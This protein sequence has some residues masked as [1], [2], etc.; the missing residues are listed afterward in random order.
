MKIV[1]AALWL[2]LLHGHTVSGQHDEEHANFSPLLCNGNFSMNCVPLN[3][4]DVKSSVYVVPC[5]ACQVLTESVNFVGGLNVEGHLQI[6]PPVNVTSVL[7]IE[8]PFIIV[9]GKL[10]VDMES[11]SFAERRGGIHIELVEGDGTDIQMVPHAENSMACGDPTKCNVGKR[12]FVVAGG[13]IDIRGYDESCPSWTNLVDVVE[14]GTTMTQL[15]A[16]EYE[17][18]PQPPSEVCSAIAVWQDFEDQSPPPNEWDGGGALEYGVKSTPTGHYFEATGNGPRVF[19]A[20]PECLTP[21]AQYLFSVTI[22][23]STL[24]GTASACS[25]YGGWN[26]PQLILKTSSGSRWGRR[27]GIFSGKDIDDGAW[28]TFQAAV[29]FTEAEVGPSSNN[30]WTSLS[31]SGLGADVKLSID[32]FLLELAPPATYHDPNQVC[33]QLLPNGDAESSSGGN[34]FPFTLSGGRAAVVEESGNKFFRQSGRYAYYNRLEAKVNTGCIVQDAVYKVSAKVQVHW[35]D[36]TPAEIVVASVQPNGSTHWSTLLL[37]PDSNE[38]SG[39]VSCEQQL[40]F[41]PQLIAATSIT[42]FIRPRG[43]G[44]YASTVDWDDLSIEYVSVDGPV[45]E[46]L[47]DPTIVHDCWAGPIS[48]GAEVLLTSHTLDYTDHQVVSTSGMTMDGKISL[49][50]PIVNPMSGAGD[51]SVEV[52]LLSRRITLEASSVSGSSI[53]GHFIVLHTPGVNQII[54]GME[55]KGFGQQGNLGRYV[56][57][58]ILFCLPICFSIIDMISL[59][60]LILLCFATLMCYIYSRS[61]S[62]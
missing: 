17:H 4:A 14:E 24:G 57:N 2:L 31:I 48:E 16:S 46:V 7:S 56:S 59:T 28:A 40:S 50:S 58:I 10:T 52:A 26:C 21:G 3:V 9:Q 53:G 5:G 45:E 47:V 34:I 1:K 62:T 15:E 60:C 54:R 43:P 22:M 38:N 11:E 12:A 27:L 25:L 49:T 30:A 42:L 35:P 20:K 29:T 6:L 32:N 36:P 8:A 39:F 13:M 44:A 55:I 19:L 37:C 33:A 61:T 18:P 51:F 23:L 41:S